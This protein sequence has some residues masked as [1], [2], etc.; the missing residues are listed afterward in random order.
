MI[1]D[2]L[3]QTASW[4]SVSSVNQYNEPTYT[5]KSISVR[6]EPSRKLVRN[7]E[8]EEVTSSAFVVTTSAVAANDLIDGRLVITS[9]PAPGLNGD[10]IFYEVYLK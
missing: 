7:N 5:T 10:Y 6:K 4:K 3:N 2:Y 1:N 8:G 9:E